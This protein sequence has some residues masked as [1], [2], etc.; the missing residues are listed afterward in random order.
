MYLSPFGK[1]HVA[2]CSLCA[3]HPGHINYKIRDAFAPGSRSRAVLVVSEAA[4][5]HSP[6][7]ALLVFYYAADYL[8]YYPKGSCSFAAVPFVLVPSTIARGTKPSP[9][10][11][12]VAAVMIF[13]FEVLLPTTYAYTANVKSVVASTISIALAIRSTS[14][15]FLVS[16]RELG[17]I[18][19][20]IVTIG[21]G[22]VDASK[23]LLASVVGIPRLVVLP[24]I[25]HIL[26]ITILD[27]PTRKP[28]AR[29]RGRRH[30]EM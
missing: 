13:S 30:R 21:A 29:E 6:N 15:L 3:A 22:P 11:I 8:G 25:N 7:V 5:G 23:I 18:E 14:A 4:G 12:A 9:L 27:L 28:C 10:F 19:R 24:S 2:K 26:G 1:S 17:V 20:V 16:R